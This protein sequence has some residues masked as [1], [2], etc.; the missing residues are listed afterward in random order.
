MQSSFLPLTS[1]EVHYA[2]QIVSLIVADSQEGGGRG[3]QQDQSV[4]RDPQHG[5]RLDRRS[6]PG[7]GADGVQVHRQGRR[8]GRVCRCPR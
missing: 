7:R 1:D 8:R 6:G 4:L 5:L 3:C 2:G